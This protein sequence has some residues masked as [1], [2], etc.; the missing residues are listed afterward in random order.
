[1]RPSL[2]RRGY[3]RLKSLAQIVSDQ[4]ARDRTFAT[5]TQDSN[6]APELS[7]RPRV[8]V[9][10]PT[11]NRPNELRRLL[12]QINSEAPGFEVS[13]HIYDDGSSEPV[14]VEWPSHP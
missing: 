2:L 6:Q 1:M 13:V 12:S 4:G 11:Y 8:Q 5:M 14:Y 10:I 9:I 7:E 3:Q